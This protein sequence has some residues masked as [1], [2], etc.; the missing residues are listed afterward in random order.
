MYTKSNYQTERDLI[1][2][3]MSNETMREYIKCYCYRCTR[4]SWCSFKD[5]LLYHDFYTLYP[6]LY[7]LIRR[8]SISATIMVK[9]LTYAYEC[10]YYGVT[11]FSSFTDDFFDQ[12]KEGVL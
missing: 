1:Q 11:N 3:F 8:K 4:V 2:T 6:A 12:I 5:Y 7:K 9:F 10:F